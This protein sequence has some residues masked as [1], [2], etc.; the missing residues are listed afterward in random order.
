[1][2]LGLIFYSCSNKSEEANKEVL[3]YKITEQFSFND[4]LFESK[5]RKYKIAVIRKDSILDWKYSR[6]KHRIKYILDSDYSIKKILNWSE[7]RKSN[8]NNKEDSVLI[9]GKLTSKEQDYNQGLK[10]LDNREKL[11]ENNI[12]FKTK[13]GLL[14]F[15]IVGYYKS[16]GL[17]LYMPNFRKLIP[18]KETNKIGVLEMNFEYTID[19]KNKRIQ[20]IISTIAA[21]INDNSI[22]LCKTTMELTKG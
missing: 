20:K 1:M 7:F 16:I 12:K 3:N 14:M 13:N 19:I 22:Y 5:S 4:S 9:I 18:I 2:I 17:D 21:P 8:N 11:K 10:F 6:H 15:T